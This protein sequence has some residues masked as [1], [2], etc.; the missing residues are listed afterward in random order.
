MG[1]VKD[2]R[3]EKGRVEVE[4]NLVKKKKKWW[5]MKGR[6]ELW[7]RMGKEKRDR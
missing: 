7:K 5:G 2:Y 3:L 6:I 4:V 1:D